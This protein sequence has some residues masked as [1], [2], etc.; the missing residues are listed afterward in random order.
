[1][2]E[3][4]MDAK[5]LLEAVENNDQD[6]V[7]SLLNQGL[8]VNIQDPFG[9]TALMNA[10][11]LVG[12]KEEVWLPM[13]EMLLAA[14]AD[15]TLQN[16]VGKT[17]LIMACQY[18]VPAYYDSNKYKIKTSLIVKKL[19]ESGADP[20]IHDRCGYTPLMYSAIS[21]YA[22]NI[23]MLFEYGARVDATDRNGENALI[24]S[25]NDITILKHSDQEVVAALL[26][27]GADINFKDKNGYT[28]LMYAV[29]P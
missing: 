28:P 7:K 26:K 18:S 10:V 12:F 9:N 22:G 13:I 6:S 25:I 16:K 8:G 24:K 5:K 3:K 29:T 1:M 17:A 19:L 2:D 27:A 4:Y 15:V 11:S 23:S 21:G 14:G 20:N